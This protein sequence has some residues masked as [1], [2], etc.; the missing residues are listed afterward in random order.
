MKKKS[1]AKAKAKRRQLFLPHAIGMTGGVALATVAFWFFKKQ[2][3]HVV[4]GRADRID[5]AIMQAVHQIDEPRV[6]D[7]MQAV[8]QLGTV[9]LVNG[10]VDG[11]NA[12][13]ASDVAAVLTELD[14]M[15]GDRTDLDGDGVVSSTDLSIVLKSLDHVGDN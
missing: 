15:G 11:N 1:N 4:A 13:T 8:T 3:D 14:A 7:V 10:D 12:V 5:D 9:E 6:H 2:A